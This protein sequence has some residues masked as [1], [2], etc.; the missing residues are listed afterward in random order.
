MIF[1][2]FSFLYVY[3]SSLLRNLIPSYSLGVAF[4]TL[5]CFFYFFI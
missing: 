2:S 1:D 5:P 4:R 3:V